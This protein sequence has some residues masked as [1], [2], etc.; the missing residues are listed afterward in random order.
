LQYNAARESRDSLANENSMLQEQM[1]E[2]LTASDVM[3][4]RVEQLECECKELSGINIMLHK[5]MQD[6]EHQLV[7][8]QELLQHQ[9]RKFPKNRIGQ[10]LELAVIEIKEHGNWENNLYSSKEKLLTSGLLDRSGEISKNE[11]DVNFDESVASTTKT[12]PPIPHLINRSQLAISKMSESIRQEVLQS[13]NVFTDNEEGEH[14]SYVDDEFYSAIDDQ[15]GAIVSALAT[16]FPDIPESPPPPPPSNRISSCNNEFLSF[17]VEE[18]NEDHGFEDAQSMLEPLPPLPYWTE[19]ENDENL[20]S[21]N[22]NVEEPV[23]AHEQQDRS[24]ILEIDLTEREDASDRHMAQLKIYE[25]SDAVDLAVNFMQQH[26]LNVKYLDPLV[27]YIINAQLKLLESKSEVNQFAD[28]HENGG[29]EF[30]NA[31]EMGEEVIFSNTNYIS[32]EN[33]DKDSAPP[34]PEFEYNEDDTY[35]NVNAV[36]PVHI[37]NN[38][39][40]PKDYIEKDDV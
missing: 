37:E 29:N 26:L 40:S 15:P 9:M 25:S 24:I 19:V 28:Y 39:R 38:A 12:R 6:M 35:G 2:C 10:Q 27:Q 14:E 13:H 3:R 36:L 8:Q 17:S 18:E 7:S 11:A 22:F 32:S 23:G 16:K 34:L 31:C 20:D 5:K 30:E 21:N 33:I 4:Q 1:Q